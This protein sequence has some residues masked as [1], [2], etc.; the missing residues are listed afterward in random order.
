MGTLN[1]VHVCVTVRPA[2]PV[3]T[4]LATRSVPAGSNTPFRPGPRLPVTPRTNTAQPRTTGAGSSTLGVAVRPRIAVGTRQTRPPTGIA[5]PTVV[6]NSV[7]ASATLPAPCM[8]PVPRR[9]MAPSRIAAIMM[10][11]QYSNDRVLITLLLL[12]FCN[13]IPTHTHTHSTSL[14]VLSVFWL[15]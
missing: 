15:F 1:I 12:I 8:L 2:A 6:Q 11:R 4:N 9:T 13:G 5:R 10:R 3:Q 14:Y 7:R